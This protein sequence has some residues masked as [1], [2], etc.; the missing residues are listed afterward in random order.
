MAAMNIH[1]K[2][3]NLTRGLVEGATSKLHVAGTFSKEITL[4][5]GVRQGCPLAPLLFSIATQPL[6]VILKDRQDAGTLHGLKI[7]GEKTMLHSLFAEDSGVMIQAKAEEFHELQDAIQCYESISGAKLNIKKST[8]I[9]IG[10]TEIPDWLRQ[11]GCHV[12]KKGEIIRYLGF[13]IGWGVSEEDQLEFFTSRMQKKLGNWKYSML[14]FAG[15]VVALKHVVRSTP[16]HLIACKQKQG[17]F[18]LTDFRLVSRAMR[19][20]QTVKL[21]M[22]AEEDWTGAAEQLIRSVN[23]KGR[24]ARNR[25]AWSVQEILILQQ[26]SRVP[27]APTI[28]GLLEVWKLMRTKLKLSQHTRLNPEFPVAKMLL[29]AEGQGWINKEDQQTCIQELMRGKCHNLGDWK[30]RSISSGEAHRSRA[31]EIGR[32]LDVHPEGGLNLHGIPTSERISKWGKSDGKCSRWKRDTESLEHLLI[33]CM[34]NQNR[35]S[36]WQQITRNTNLKWTHQG[37]FIRMIDEALK[38]R[39]GAKVTLM[40][41][42]CWNL[43]LDRNHATFSAQIRRTPLHVTATQAKFQLATMAA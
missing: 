1:N 3:I 34:E 10:L 18:G 41:K 21:F 43:W 38:Q 4:E 22:Q 13:P 11:V 9:P 2:F 6:M 32:R 19:M 29:L 26:P 39:T 12:A 30:H 37:D 40:I 35:W 24:A 28:S 25:E 27:A 15:R 20:K 8:V 31:R 36:E 7:K 5:R 14:S 16:V 42:T 33:D 23:K 17:G